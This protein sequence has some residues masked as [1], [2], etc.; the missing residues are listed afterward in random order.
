M[1]NKEKQTKTILL[2]RETLQEKLGV[3]WAEKLPAKIKEMA[4]SRQKTAFADSWLE[5]EKSDLLGFVDFG[6]LAS[7][8]RRSLFSR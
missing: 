7:Q 8:F 5:G 4:T 1:E 6:Q 3:D 2:I